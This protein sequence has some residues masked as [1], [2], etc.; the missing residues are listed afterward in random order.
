MKSRNIE[1]FDDD[2]AVVIYDNSFLERLI[3]NENELLLLNH[4]DDITI[5]RSGVMNLNGNRIK[6][7]LYFDKP[8]IDLSCTLIGS[9]FKN[10]ILKR[11]D[12]SAVL[13][14]QKLSD[15]NITSRTEQILTRDEVKKYFDHTNYDAMYLANK[16]LGL[17]FAYNKEDGIII[18]HN[19]VPTNEELIE[20]DWKQR[21]MQLRLYH[22]FDDRNT[23]TPRILETPL[24]ESIDSLKNVDIY[25]SLAS[26]CSDIL[27]TSKN[28]KLKA[29]WI[30]LSFLGKEQ[31]RLITKEELLFERDT[32]FVLEGNTTKEKKDKTKLKSI[33]KK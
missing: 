13:F 19:I 29:N 2:G 17:T 24:A 9:N 32:E 8:Y 14:E 21:E 26:D 6:Q 4:N 22:L 16:R 10:Y 1:K 15:K 20:L 30:Y 23:C 3:V 7:K 18:D 12:G 25:Y 27:I 5:N 31:F 11:F 33:F 28:G